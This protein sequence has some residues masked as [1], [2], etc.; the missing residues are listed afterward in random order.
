MTQNHISVDKMLTPGQKVRVVRTVEYA[1]DV[2]IA[3]YLAESGDSDISVGELQT[4]IED[5]HEVSDIS[6]DYG[7]VDE[8]TI[9]V[10][11]VEIN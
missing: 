3:D 8:V 4:D 9:S 5:N 11:V 2:D 1:Y 6:D 7:D 10:T